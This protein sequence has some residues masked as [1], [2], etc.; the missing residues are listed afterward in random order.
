MLI[1][2]QRDI[3]SP[4]RASWPAPRQRSP[5]GRHV[6]TPGRGSARGAARMPSRQP[7]PAHYGLMKV[8]Y[9]RREVMEIL[10][11]GET[12]LHKLTKLGQLKCAKIGKTTVFYAVDLAAFIEFSRRQGGAS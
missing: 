11:I 1:C 6:W 2:E 4:L 7:P 9:R 12:S 5:Y 3:R 8:A 10:R